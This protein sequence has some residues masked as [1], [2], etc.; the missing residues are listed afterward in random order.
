MKQAVSR[1][2]DK[3]EAGGKI[4]DILFIDGGLGQLRIAQKI[5]DEKF[6]HL[7]KAPQLIGVAKGE[8]VNLDSKP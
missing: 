4:P 7:D 1:R 3:I 2:F 5:V 6:V 8:A